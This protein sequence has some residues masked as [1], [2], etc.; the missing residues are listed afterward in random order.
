[1]PSLPLTVAILRSRGERAAAEL[2]A[3]K[4]VIILEDGKEGSAE[5]LIKG[6]IV[7]LFV[8][9][10]TIG[11][12]QDVIIL[13]WFCSVYT[14]EFCGPNENCSIH[15][16]ILHIEGPRFSWLKNVRLMCDD[17]WRHLADFQKI[18]VL[19]KANTLTADVVRKLC[20]DK[21]DLECHLER[22]GNRAGDFVRN[23]LA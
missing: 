23:L 11:A 14:C 1:M 22:I 5:D 15:F 20:I 7:Q 21:N 8:G 9:R 12:E 19:A 4:P 2:R 17:G 13:G 16:E 10:E 18:Q 3:R 6:M